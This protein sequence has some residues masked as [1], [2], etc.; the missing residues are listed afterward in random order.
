MFRGADGSL[1][2]YDG[3]QPITVSYEWHEYDG[4]TD[5]IV[6]GSG[7]GPTLVLTTDQVGQTIYY[8]VTPTNDVGNGASL[9][10]AATAPVTFGSVAGLSCSGGTHITCSW[11]PQ[12]GEV[13]LFD[14]QGVSS[15]TFDWSTSTPDTFYG[16]DL[17]DHNADESITRLDS[18]TLPF[19]NGSAA[20]EVEACTDPSGTING[21]TPLDCLGN[22]TQSDTVTIS[23]SPS[24]CPPDLA[25][26]NVS[27]AF[28]CGD[29]VYNTTP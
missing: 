8:I 25:I 29:G 10:S 16:S 28:W 20:F 12:P 11:T 14:A 6:P 19:R 21:A 4:V 7:S 1:Q 18:V 27:Y 9:V 26:T 23:G 24:S 13:F 15:G 5:Q 17:G 2:Y 3:E 22:F